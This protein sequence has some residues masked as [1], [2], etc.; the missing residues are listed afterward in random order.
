[1]VA[2]A[3]VWLVVSRKVGSAIA[4]RSSPPRSVRI[5]P[6]QAPTVSSSA[7]PQPTTFHDRIAFPSQAGEVPPDPVGRLMATQPGQMPAAFGKSG[8]TFGFLRLAGDPG[9]RD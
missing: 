4:M 1:M 7:S 2:E 9:A 8:G 5:G 6:S 3:S